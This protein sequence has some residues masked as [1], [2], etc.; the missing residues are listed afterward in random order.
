MVHLAV[1]GMVSPS[2]RSQR[3][4]LAEGADD[5]LQQNTVS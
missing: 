3:T 2:L 1:G 4:G 5:I